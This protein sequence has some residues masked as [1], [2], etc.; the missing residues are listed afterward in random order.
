[1]SVWC[2][3]LHAPHGEACPLRE[4]LRVPDPIWDALSCVWA[5]GALCG[6]FN[7]IEK[8]NGWLKRAVAE[9]IEFGRAS[10][11]DVTDAI[12]GAI[13]RHAEGMT[14]RCRGWID[15]LFGDLG[16]ASV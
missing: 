10:F 15:F 12:E 1:M 13:E 6:R 11:D 16:A 14:A 9:D 4:R 8:F 7:P 5:C 2:G 3:F